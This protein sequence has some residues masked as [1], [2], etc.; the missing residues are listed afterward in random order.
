MHIQFRYRRIGNRKREKIRQEYNKR[1]AVLFLICLWLL[2]IGLE[3]LR[4]WWVPVERFINI[5][6]IARDI[7]VIWG[8]CPVCVIHLMEL[9]QGGKNSN[10]D[11]ENPPQ[12]LIGFLLVIPFKFVAVTCTNDWYSRDVIFYIFQEERGGTEIPP[13]HNFLW[14]SGKK[15]PPAPAELENSTSNSAPARGRWWLKNIKNNEEKQLIK[16]PQ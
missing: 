4:T 13:F 11:E 15:G 6:R 7:Q 1:M 2:S 12:R 14:K 16:H 3:L 8:S 5:W 9:Y 10:Q